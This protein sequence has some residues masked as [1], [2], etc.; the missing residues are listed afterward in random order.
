[1]KSPRENPASPNRAFE[2]VIFDMDG[3]LIVPL[4]DF[5][6]IRAEF[7][8]APG[9]SVLESIHG[10]PGEERRKAHDR[11]VE[12]EVAAARQAKLLPGAVEIVAAVRSAG[13]KTALLT[14]NTREA[15]NIVLA[16]HPSLRFD[17]VMSRED[18]SAKPEPDGIYQACKTFGVLPERTC[19]VGDYR[20]DI[21][22]ANAAGATS[23]LLTTQRDRPDFADWCEQADYRIDRLNELY[24]ILEL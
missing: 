17:L 12:I 18:G 23:V 11:L 4:L 7:G 9:Q 6:A 5:D 19:C 14:R 3:T 1:M 15:M 22:A 21:L 24:P 10:R 20:Y 8:V 16:N 2:A 13:L